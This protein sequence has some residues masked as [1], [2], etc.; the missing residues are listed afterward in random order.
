MTTRTWLWMVPIGLLVVPV[1]AW[2]TRSEVIQKY[3]SG[4]QLTFTAERGKELWNKTVV[5]KAGAERGCNTCHGKDLTKPG[6]HEKTGKVIDPMAPS[7]NPERFTD[8]AKVEK[9]LK[10]N[11]KETFDRECTDQE[12]GDVLTY[13]SQL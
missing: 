5:G 3:N 2:A 1:A 12:K 7:V 8:A 10:R 9:W 6:K 11:C 4:G 13:L